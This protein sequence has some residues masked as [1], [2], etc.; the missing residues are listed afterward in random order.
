MFHKHLG[1]RKGG[2]SLPGGTVGLSRRMNTWEEKKEFNV[3]VHSFIHGPGTVLGQ[4][5]GGKEASKAVSSWASQPQHICCS[6]VG[7]SRMMG[8]FQFERGPAGQSGIIPQ[9]RF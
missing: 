8:M 3:C 7:S 6:A 2:C 5:R 9:H 4:E 1:P